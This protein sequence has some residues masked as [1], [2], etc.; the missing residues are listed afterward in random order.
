MV[1]KRAASWHFWKG[2]R[3]IAIAC[4]RCK[5]VFDFEDALPGDAPCDETAVK[6]ARFGGCQSYHEKHKHLPDGPNTLNA[7]SAWPSLVLASLSTKLPSESD[8][9]LA[10]ARRQRLISNFTPGYVL[11]TDFSGKQCPETAY[12]MMGVAMQEAGWPVPAWQDWLVSWRACDNDK[13]CQ[14]IMLSSKHRTE[15]ILPEIASRLPAKLQRDITMLRPIDTATL[16]TKR[17]AYANMK[18]ML[19]KRKASIFKTPP[20]STCLAH[21]GQLCPVTWTNPS[22]ARP[23]KRPRLS[24]IAGTL[25]TPWSSLGKRTGLGHPATEPW[26]VWAADVADTKYDEISFENSPHFPIDLFKDVVGQKAKVVS[27]VFGPQ[28]FIVP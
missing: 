28:D 11:H 23:S 6:R 15:H 7:F 1:R 18:A 14:E 26:W 3:S 20:L 2:A 13:R 24:N 27:I 5:T 12:R 10:N 4:A 9:A 21:P 16:E 22:D 8:D 25:C 17:V 19:W